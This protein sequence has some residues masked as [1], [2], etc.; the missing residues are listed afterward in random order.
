MFKFRGAAAAFPVEAGTW[1][2]RCEAVYRAIQE[3]P[4]NPNV[5]AV[6]E[7]GLVD[8]K[9]VRHDIPPKVW[10]R[11]I[12]THNTFHAGSGIN[13]VDFLNDAVQMESD[14]ELDC[15]KTGLHSANPRYK[16]YYKDFVLGKSIL[17]DRHE[18]CQSV[19]IT[20][21]PHPFL[22]EVEVM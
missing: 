21:S 9:F 14:W 6:L 2:H 19:T 12:G 16:N 8:V 11:F 5:S 10:S 13:F 3:Q 22:V 1:N 20:D 7:R 17:A 15:S 4:T 18:V